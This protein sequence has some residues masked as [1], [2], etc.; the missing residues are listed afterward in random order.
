MKVNLK[1]IREE[2][3]KRCKAGPPS[4]YQDLWLT[5]NNLLRDFETE[6]R[7]PVNLHE[8]SKHYINEKNYAWSRGSKE[9]LKSSEEFDEITAY[10]L[11]FIDG[12]LHLKNE[13]LGEEASE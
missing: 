10:I 9:D 3:A 8:L 6:L 1:K 12:Y 13:I 11:G 5:M 7:Q 2:L 4:N